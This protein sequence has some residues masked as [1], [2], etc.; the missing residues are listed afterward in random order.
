MGAPTHLLG[1]R[2]CRQA[3]GAA[4]VASFST[5][6]LINE[7]GPFWEAVGDAGGDALSRAY[8]LIKRRASRKL[9]TLDL[10]TFT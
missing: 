7:S 3:F 8:I 10:R 1:L 2:V 4:G 6:S 9:P 5:P